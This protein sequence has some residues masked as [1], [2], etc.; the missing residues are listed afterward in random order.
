MRQGEILGL[1][2]DDISWTTGEIKVRRALGRRTWRHGCSDKNSCS[3]AR[4]HH[5]PRRVGGG[6]LSPGR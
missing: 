4:P 6:G 5:C 2:W 1:Q 3:A